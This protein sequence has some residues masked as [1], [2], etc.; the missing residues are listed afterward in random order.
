M[1]HFLYSANKAYEK[2][3]IAVTQTDQEVAGE[4]SKE[5]TSLMQEDSFREFLLERWKKNNPGLVDSVLKDSPYS[6]EKEL[7]K[8]KEEEKK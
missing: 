8:I 4:F 7:K 5:F 2:T 1:I 3:N 6:K